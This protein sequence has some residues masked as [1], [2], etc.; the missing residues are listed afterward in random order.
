MKAL[1]GIYYDEENK[2]LIIFSGW[3]CYYNGEIIKIEIIKEVSESTN[4]VISED[5]KEST[6]KSMVPWYTLA[7]QGEN[8]YVNLSNSSN[9]EFEIIIWNNEDYENSEKIYKQ[10]FRCL[11][12]STT[13]FPEIEEFYKSIDCKYLYKSINPY[14]QDFNEPREG[15]L[16]QDVKYTS[17]GEPEK[18]NKKEYTFG[19]YEQW[20]Y[21]NCKY[22]YIKD[23]VVD[24]IQE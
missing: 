10:H 1:N 5:G 15:D 22:V 6:E 8:I 13:N 2:D 20:C 9:D 3:D 7:L 14:N 19:T 11:D 21:P 4:I 24:K 23:G 16:Y 12:F 18:I 17:W